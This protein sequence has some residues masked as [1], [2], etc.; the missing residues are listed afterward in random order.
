ML[1]FDEMT[2]NFQTA[3]WILIST[4]IRLCLRWAA[5]VSYNWSLQF[6]HRK[7]HL[8][9]F[10]PLEAIVKAANKE[11]DYSIFSKDTV[12]HALVM[13]KWHHVRPQFM[14]EFR[15]YAGYLV[16]CCLWSLLLVATRPGNQ[17][18]SAIKKPIEF[19]SNVTWHLD[20]Q[21]IHNVS[22]FTLCSEVMF[23]EQDKSNVTAAFQ[24]IQWILQYLPDPKMLKW[25]TWITEPLLWIL[26]AV[27]LLF[28]N[29]Y[30]QRECCQFFIE[31]NT[32]EGSFK[33]FRSALWQHF[34]T[35][36]WNILDILAFVCQIWASVAVVFDLNIKYDVAAYSILFL[37][38]KVLFYFRAFKGC[39]SF[40][41]T[42]QSTIVSLGAFLAVL[43][44]LLG[45][46][47]FAF[48]VCYV[49]GFQDFFDAI[50]AVAMLLFGQFDEALMDY[51]YSHVQTA[52]MLIT[53][54]F[55]CVIVMLNLLVA[56]VTAH[57]ET[58][59]EDVDQVYILSLA[60]IV[61]EH[62]RVDQ[63]SG[64]SCSPSFQKWVHIL[65]PAATSRQRKE[66]EKE[67]PE[68]LKLK[69][70]IDEAVKDINVRIDDVHKEINEF[71]TKVDDQ[72][73]EI[74]RLLSQQKKAQGKLVD[75][76][77]RSSECGGGQKS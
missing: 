66:E 14:Y 9:H 60:S 3:T 48:H 36:H 35:D 22:N 65:K 39:G 38:A 41:I 74:V 26:T 28:S 52:V 68:I 77:G 31:F 54:L 40:V 32:L 37:F 12:V 75:Q 21:V 56:I 17:H 13:F 10:S 7:T 47:A 53:F 55:F 46:Y 45:G 64:D 25:F 15:K 4:I 33:D 76:E 49:K 11:E 42:I 43:A 6:F 18:L 2:R 63:E 8:D 73:A 1:F 67:K 59:R 69:T 62:E 57:F 5:F 27:V 19:C 71:G 58:I 30:F 61:I 70:H 20:E 29:Y 16:L 51:I 44:V 50:V 72:F 24:F 23:P 34:T